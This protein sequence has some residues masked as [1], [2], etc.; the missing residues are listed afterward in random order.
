MAELERERLQKEAEENGS[1]EE[2]EKIGVKF[3]IS[4]EAPILMSKAC[5]LLIKDL[6]FRAWQHTERNRRRT[7][8]RQD[9]HAA[10]GESEVYDFLI[11]IVPRV[12]PIPAA[13]PATATTTMNQPDMTQMAMGGRGLPP[14]MQVPQMGMNPPGL[15]HQAMGGV[16]PGH[17]HTQQTATVPGALDSSNP[18]GGL[19][20]FAQTSDAL[21]QL[22]GWDPSQIQGFQHMHTPDASDGQTAGQQ[23]GQSHQAQH[24]PQQWVDPATILGGPHQ[25]QPAPGV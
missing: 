21:H 15:Q 24:N 17:V 9:L 16:S 23:H 3:M 2:P 4:G 10:V 1:T 8:Q 14:P 12:Q 20:H 18:Q 25:Q 5:E 22:Q 6:S 7:L 13:L 11:D 19:M